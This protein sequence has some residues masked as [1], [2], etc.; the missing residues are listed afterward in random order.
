MG[1]LAPA[2]S[3]RPTAGGEPAD[4]RS[5]DALTLAG[6]AAA[7]FALLLRIPTLSL[8]LVEAHAFRQ[9]Q[10]AWTAV[11]YHREGI[12]LFQTP[13]PT[14]GPPWVVPFEF[15]LFQGIAAVAM[16]LGVPT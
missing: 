13:M 5:P 10:T 8:P 7:T 3:T 15:P 1:V 4:V 11:I 6:L 14:L 16:D 12:N 9:T 2:V